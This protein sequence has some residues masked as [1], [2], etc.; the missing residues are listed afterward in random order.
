MTITNGYCELADVRELLGVSNPLETTN[1]LLIEKVI[2]A[3]S[4]AIDGWCGRRFYTTSTDETKYYTA[5]YYNALFPDIDILSITTLKTDTNGDGV[6][7]ITWATTDY[8]LFP[9]NKPYKTVIEVDPAGRYNF[10]KTKHGVQIVGKFGYCAIADRPPEITTFCM[11][12]AVR[13]FKRMSE[14]PF[15]VMGF[16]ETGQSTIIPSDDPD[17]KMLIGKFRRLI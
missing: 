10:P 5:D 3:A 9:F 15:G 13:L 16:S 11:L 1:D 14:A 2:E 6:F 8:L 7:E 17:A 4:R 12:L